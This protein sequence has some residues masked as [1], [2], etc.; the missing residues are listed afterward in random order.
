MI[1]EVPAVEKP[2]TAR[3]T[4]HQ[5]GSMMMPLTSAMMAMIEMKPEKALTWPTR[6]TSFG[7]TRQPMTKPPAHEVPSRPS[8]VVA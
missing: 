5:I 8:V 4:T 7:A 6:R 1:I 3:R 2:V